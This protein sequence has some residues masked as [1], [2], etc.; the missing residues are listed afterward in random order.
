MPHAH[1]EQVAQG[2]NDVFRVEPG[3]YALR[4]QRCSLIDDSVAASQLA[5]LEALAAA[6][7]VVPRPVRLRD[8]R[9]FFVR[10]GRRFVLLEWIEGDTLLSV[11]PVD[12]AA[13][14]G[15]AIA[16]LHRHAASWTVPAGFACPRHDCRAPPAEPLGLSETDAAT[17]ERSAR[18]VRSVMDEVGRTSDTYGVVHGDLNF[19]NFVLHDGEA[20]P[21]DFDEFGFGFYLSDIAEPL[22]VLVFREDCGAMRAALLEAY[23]RV[24]PL[25]SVHE[26]RL[27]TFIAGGFLATLCWAS[28]PESAAHR[29]EI[30]PWVGR[31]IGEIER[32]TA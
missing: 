28:R 27:D 17:L 9:W 29:H 18:R 7:V 25:S 31:W 8:G 14:V 3:P 2:A 11:N 24:R 5:W 13:L 12:A 4:V 16:R 19:D 23:R 32:L 30:E 15:A 1:L 26:A 21:I 10:D 22:R 6:G 20:C